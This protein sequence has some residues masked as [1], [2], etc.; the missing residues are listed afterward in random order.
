MPTR[1]F[2]NLQ[3]ILLFLSAC[4]AFSNPQGNPPLNQSDAIQ[5]ASLIVA[6][7]DS[8]ATP[9]PFQPLAPSPT[10]IPT[11]YLNPISSAGPTLDA[12]ATSA[13][14]PITWVGYPGPTIYPPIA[15]PPPMGIWDQPANQIN[16]LLM[17]SDQRPYEGGFRTDVLLLATL[18]TNLG[19]VSL[20]SF[21]RD[22]FVYI[23]GWTM[24]RIN[25]AH[26]RGGFQLTELTFEYNFGVRPD[27]WVMINFNGFLT[28]ID[29]LGGIDVQ[30]GRTLS[31]QR[32]KFG[33]YTVLAGIVH[34][35]GETTLWYVRSRGTSSDFDRTRRQQEV[36]QAIF[37][38]TLSL[39]GVTRAPQLYQ[40][41][42][43]TVLTNLTLDDILPLLSLAPQLANGNGFSRYA[44][45]PNQVTP[46][47]NPFNGAQVLLPN[48]EAVRAI[49]NQ[50]LNIP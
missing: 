42:I 7:P 36:L 32:D 10:F 16:I 11:D 2:I 15:I 18:N 30:V 49:M 6:P 39:D 46:W 24:E 38:K 41:Y 29:A 43:E 45:G 3:V 26:A 40:Q 14:F 35:D 50:A 12:I 25:T 31:D 21:P 9:T 20:T 4:S 23:P 27:Y 48:Q 5:P 8:T 28:M 34:M 37:F 19:T 33:V 44:V 17:G 1:N 47:V 22:L 13:T